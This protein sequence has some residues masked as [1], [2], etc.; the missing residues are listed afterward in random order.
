MIELFL[1][2]VHVPSLLAE[3]VAEKPAIPLPKRMM[4]AFTAVKLLE[5]L[6]TFYINNISYIIDLNA[7]LFRMFVMFTLAKQNQAAYFRDS[8]A[9]GWEITGP[10]CTEFFKNTV[11]TF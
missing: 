1:E 5:F 2:S 7:Y 6:M 9:N 8:D 11:V 3:A 10:H 4:V